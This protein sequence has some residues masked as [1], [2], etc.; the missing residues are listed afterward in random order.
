[1]STEP[2]PS[3]DFQQITDH[4]LALPVDQRVVLLHKLNDSINEEE[5]TPEHQERVM[6]VVRQRAEE[7]RNG[8]A[9]EVSHEEV[10]EFLNRPAQCD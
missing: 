6:E 2:Q 7:M 9:E 1:M 10:M 4:A 3:A 8:T 5:P